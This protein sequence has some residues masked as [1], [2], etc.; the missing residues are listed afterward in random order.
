MPLTRSCEFQC[1]SK[2]KPGATACNEVCLRSRLTESNVSEHWGGMIG[3]VV[4]SLN[5]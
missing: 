5:P 2:Q 3:G 1:A 4:K